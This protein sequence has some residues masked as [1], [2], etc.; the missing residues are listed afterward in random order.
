MISQSLQLSSPDD[1]A[2]VRS[3]TERHVE[4][5]RQAGPGFGFGDR[6][7]FLTQVTPDDLNMARAEVSPGH[8]ERV[9]HPQTAATLLQGAGTAQPRI[10][11]PALVA[12]DDPDPGR[13]AAPNQDVTALGTMSDG[14]GKEL[15]DRQGH[16][17]R[18]DVTVVPASDRR[19]PLPRLLAGSRA[20]FEHAPLQRA[21]P[22]QPAAS[23]NK[24]APAI[25]HLVASPRCPLH[26]ETPGG[27]GVTG[28][29]F[30]PDSQLLATANR[31]DVRLWDAATGQPIGAPLSGNTD[32]HSSGAVVVAFGPGG[33]FIAGSF[34]YHRV[35]LWNPA[36]GKTLGPPIPAP[37]G[38]DDIRAVAFSPDGKLLAISIS[39]GNIQLWD[40]ATGQRAGAAIRI[41][42]RSLITTL[43]FSPDGRMLAGGESAN[44]EVR[45]WNAITGR[46]IGHP[47]PAKEV[48]SVAFSPDGRI[49]A[50]AN[51]GGTVRLWDPVTGRPLGAP[52]HAAPGAGEGVAGVAFSPDGRLMATADGNGDVRLWNPATKRPVG[53]PLAA[54][55][56]RGGVNSVAFSPDG[57]L[58]ASA[59]SD[60]TVWLWKMWLFS[61]PYRALCV[62]AGMPSRQDWEKYSPG[63]PQPLPCSHRK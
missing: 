62:S 23:L 14:V 46:P 19:D 29:V 6:I 1:R 2:G 52:I 35:R 42:S 15:A 17:S 60:G 12:D 24:T 16:I 7:Q 34:G 18:V 54:D 56:G 27:D 11:L 51:S 48:S 59:D 61:N 50:S 4:D 13:Q 39:D 40:P 38:K 55:P 31:D 8:R 53:V 36:T 45:L 5:P 26:A 43:A 3:R 22:R 57:R 41:N 32:T 20:A 30:S 21:R 58:L 9:H 44:G 25:H 49:L 37:S 10:R 63:E 28:A 47:L 33:H